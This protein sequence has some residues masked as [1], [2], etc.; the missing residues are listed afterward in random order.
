MYTFNFKLKGSKWFEKNVFCIFRLGSVGKACYDY[1]L[2]HSVCPHLY[3]LR[4]Q[5]HSWSLEQSSIIETILRA[6]KKTTLS[7][8]DLWCR[9]PSLNSNPTKMCGPTSRAWF[10]KNIICPFPNSQLI[11][12]CS[13]YYLSYNV[14]LYSFKSIWILINFLS[15]L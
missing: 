6:I 5:Q 1:L 14:I 7:G 4:Q 2:F 9:E 8:T 15:S 12:Y 10:K 3:R 11:M 13:E